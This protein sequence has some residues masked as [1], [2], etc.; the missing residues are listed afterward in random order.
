M[1]SVRDEILGNIKQ[2]ERPWGGFRQFAHNALCTVKI[3]TVT[4][5]QILSLQSHRHRD[6]LWVVLDE[7]LKVEIDGQEHLAHPGDEFVIPRGARHRVGSAGGTGRILEISFGEF[8][9][10]DIERYEDRYGRT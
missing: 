8:D 10:D 6:E 7:G 2:D 1:R 4:D 5:G 9:E 3:L